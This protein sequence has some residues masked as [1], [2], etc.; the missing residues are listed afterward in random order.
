MGRVSICA[1]SVFGI[2]QAQ[3]APNTQAQQG[4]LVTRCG[5]QQEN[6]IVH[7]TIYAAT[8]VVNRDDIATT[9]S[10]TPSLNDLPVLDLD[11]DLAFEV[12]FT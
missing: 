2:S 5:E 3:R 9:S 6:T 1:C 8:G 7:C 10:I 4:W 12:G 11:S